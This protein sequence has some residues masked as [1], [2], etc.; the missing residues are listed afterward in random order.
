M[1]ASI[2]YHPPAEPERFSAISHPIAVVD[3]NRLLANLRRM[4]A[5]ADAGGASLRPHV[6]SHN[7]PRIG[8]LARALGVSAITVSSIEMARRFADAGYD[9]ITIAFPLNVR[10]LAEVQRLAATIRLGVLVDSAP[11]ASALDEVVAPVDVW[12][13]VD[14]GYGRTGVR[15][16][17][18]ASLAAV[19]SLVAATGRHRLRGVLTHAGQ[20]YGM[21]DVSARTALWSEV[22]ARMAGA[23]AILLASG[24]PEGL[25]IS[26][27]DTPTSSVAPSFEGVD[28]VRSGNFVFYDLQ[29]LAL[30]AC[31]SG[32]LALAIACPVVGVYPQRAEIVVQGGA[33]HL[34]RD[35]APALDGV[36]GHGQLAVME[37]DHWDLLP[38][39]SGYVRRLSQEHG[40]IRCSPAVLG[41]VRV[42]DLL[43]IIPAHACLAAN[44]IGEFVFLDTPRD[45]FR[46]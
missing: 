25:L 32:D 40:M 9:D 33:I 34:S 12:L 20:A 26:V 17:D 13:D 44:Q 31:S 6:K 35:V 8:E 43:F 16:D 23:R 36:P 24:A 7:S 4:R 5:R 38:S 2:G 14:V 3:R 19:V 11:A 30:G 21:P 45:P 10:G 15:W 39:E 27:G 41:R 1:S 18:A 42:G 46:D 22:V 37:A 29:Q 28:E